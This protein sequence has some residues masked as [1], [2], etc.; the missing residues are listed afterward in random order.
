MAHLKVLFPLAVVGFTVC[1]AFYLQRRADIQLIGAGA[2]LLGTVTTA[3]CKL[4]LPIPP[5]YQAAPCLV[6]L[7]VDLIVGVGLVIKGAFSKRDLAMAL[8]YGHLDDIHPAFYGGKESLKAYFTTSK[9]A[10]SEPILLAHHVGENE[11]ELSH[12]LYSFDASVQQHWLA[13]GGGNRTI[14][15]G[16]RQDTQEDNSLQKYVQYTW[17]D[18]DGSADQHADDDEDALR[19]A[20]YSHYNTPKFTQNYFN[21]C[22]GLK[23]NG[24]LAT[25]GALYATHGEHTLNQPGEEA[26]LAAGCN[27][28]LKA[29]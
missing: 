12:W 25:G 26:G 9:R 24:K 17:D 2:T 1:S 18:D 11:G 19:Q 15:L 23:V 20:Y 8:Q 27:G 16:R 13:V 5:P 3:A 28:R 14:T 21:T 6:A 29:M 7:G 22:M 4:K 10:S